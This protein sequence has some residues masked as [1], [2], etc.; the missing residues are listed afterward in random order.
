MFITESVGFSAHRF[1]IA[2]SAP[3]LARLISMA[4]SDI[5]SSDIG[6]RTSSDCSMVNP[7]SKFPKKKQRIDQIFEMNSYTKK[8]AAM[9]SSTE[10]INRINPISTDPFAICLLFI[11]FVIQSSFKIY[12]NL[13]RYSHVYNIHNS[14]RFMFN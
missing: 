7:F 8:R 5:N 11:L 2:A 13:Y 4:T 14:S 1:Y 10:Y 6:T 12:C 3:S 9:S